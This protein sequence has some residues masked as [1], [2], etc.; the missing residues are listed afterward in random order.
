[1]PAVLHCTDRLLHGLPGAAEAQS[2]I[3]SPVVTSQMSLT[4]WFASQW[5][6]LK[7]RLAEGTRPRLL[8]IENA[9]RVLSASRDEVRQSIGCRS[10]STA[11]DQLGLP[12]ATSEPSRA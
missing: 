9:E 5:N 2:C 3:F 11:R 1:M 10:W 4:T 12:T 6:D 7:A 8:C